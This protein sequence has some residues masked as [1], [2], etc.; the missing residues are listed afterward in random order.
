MVDYRFIEASD[1]SFDFIVD[2]EF[3]TDIPP[4]KVQNALCEICNSVLIGSRLPIFFEGLSALHITGKRVEI[5]FRFSNKSDAIVTLDSSARN[6][7]PRTRTHFVIHVFARLDKVH[8]LG[9]VPFPPN[10]RDF[11][12]LDVW[13]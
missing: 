7:L 8:K 11:I 13:I 9:A 4:A 12:D 5:S 3:D 1:E 6:E 10:F 2:A